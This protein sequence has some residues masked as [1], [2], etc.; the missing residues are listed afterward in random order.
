[1]AGRGLRD[2]AVLPSFAALRPERRFLSLDRPGASDRLGDARGQPSS[3]SRERVELRAQLVQDLDPGRRRF[4][5]AYT[6]DLLAP[7]CRRPTCD[8]S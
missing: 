2:R 5:A 3:G 4:G 8:R 1:M 7:A 6:L